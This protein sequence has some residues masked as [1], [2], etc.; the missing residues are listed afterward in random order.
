MPSRATSLPLQSPNLRLPPASGDALAMRPRISGSA[1]CPFMLAACGYNFDPPKQV[2]RE[3]LASIDELVIWRYVIAGSFLWTAGDTQLR[4]GPGMALTTHQPAPTRLV[5]SGEGVCVLWILSFGKPAQ[6]YFD[7]IVARFGRSH[8]LAP[9]SEP[10][11]RAEELVRLVR[12]NKARSPFFWSEQFFLWLSAYHRHLDAHR[13]P[14]QK[15]A[16]QPEQ[17]LRLL[18]SLPRT[19]KSFAVQLGYS[20]AHFSRQLAKKWKDTPGRL[21]RE[22]RLRQAAQLLRNTEERVQ[23]IAAKTG[24]ASVPAFITAFKK[25]HG[26]TPLDYRHAQ[27]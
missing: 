14:L 1:E 27:R 6:D 26:R 12:Q 24:Y 23:T 20:P 17:S 8:T 2:F 13:L 7:R 22:L 15:V 18:P 16:A 21:L 11:R 5:V 19:V 3:Y 10:V 4:V 9:S 25:A